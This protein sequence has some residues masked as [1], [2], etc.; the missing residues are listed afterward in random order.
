[1]E[2]P[3][4]HLVDP[5]EPQAD[6]SN[7]YADPFDLFGMISPAHWINEFLKELVGWDVIGEMTASFT[8]EWE[9][10]AKC[11]AAFDNL[12]KCMQDVGV[13]IQQ[14]ALDVDRK[15]SGN[16]ADAAYLY[17][18]EVAAA[19]S[20]MQLALYEAAERYAD[21]SRGIWLF[22]D[23]VAGILESVVDKAVLAGI[24]AAAGTVLAETGVGAVAGYGLAA[25]Q[26]AQIIE[27]IGK[28]GVIIQTAGT[29][30]EGIAG[31]IMGLANQG[32]SLKKIQFPGGAYNHP[33]VA[34]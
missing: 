2:D 20:S 22:A 14:G 33:A 27:L 1:M 28:A 6:I 7:G 30:I 31:L 18:S 29:V 9:A 21:A 10:Y 11:G 26:I 4:R 24:C 8:G 13:N 16:A 12:G 25:L 23:Q 32:G 15:W 5:G 3:T 34:S 19:T 17:F